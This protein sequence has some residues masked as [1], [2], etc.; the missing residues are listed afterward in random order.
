MHQLHLADKLFPDYA[1]AVRFDVGDEA[2]NCI[3]T[4]IRI[5]SGSP[6]LLEVWLA[7]STSGGVTAI[8]PNS[9]T[10]NTG[11]V[12]DT[13]AANKHYKILAPSTGVV[14][15]TVSYP[16]DNT[17]YWAAARQGRV[18]YSAGLNFD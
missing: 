18:V 12:I 3:T 2:S 5:D 8:P 16:A 15:V 14:S 10:F 11:V 1:V 4:L 9:V 17:W 13:F 7:D 6:T